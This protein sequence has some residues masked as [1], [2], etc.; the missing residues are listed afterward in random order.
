MVRQRGSLAAAVILMCSAGAVAIHAADDNRISLVLNAGT[1][2]RVS[3][4]E[5]LTVRSVGQP[6]TATVVEDTYAYDR[7]VVPKGTQAVGRVARLDN[8]SKGVRASRL[9]NGD[10]APLHHVFVQFDTLV[11]SDG[12]RLPM[13]TKPAI[14]TPNVSLAVAETPEPTTRAGRARKEAE[15]QVSES[16]HAITKPGRME[17]LREMLINSLP[18]H[19]EHLPRGTR[20]AAQL[21]E[22]LAFGTAPRTEYAP[23]DATPPPASMLHARL[24]DTLDSA[25]T[26]RGT[27]IRALLTE[28]VMSA[29]GKLILPEGTELDGQVTFAKPARR[30]HRTGQL[31]FLFQNVRVPNQEQKSMLASL[32]STQLGQGVAIDDEGGVR[33]PETRTRFV[34]PV[35]AA[36]LARATLEN[37]TI[38]PAGEVGGVGLPGANVLGRGAGGFIG[39]GALGAVLSQ[40]GKPVAVALGF[41]GVGRSV[42]TNLLGKGRDVVM[43]AD[44]PIQLQLSPVAPDDRSAA[45]SDGR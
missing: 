5:R 16:I 17:R 19:R 8:L 35:I 24:L 15:R 3:L 14:G 4:D 33:A 18:Y 34:A 37:D 7:V 20:Y 26:G 43:P 41:Y 25:K 9:L 11:F 40:A 27:P 22:P 12:R 32:S 45:G 21:A 28:P 30:L 13:V 6:V 23:A 44:T 42:Y 39:L 36:V 31:R 1:P 29:D 2:L 10:L 38:E